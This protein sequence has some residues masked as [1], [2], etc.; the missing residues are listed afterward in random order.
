MKLANAIVT[1]EYNTIKSVT[2]IPRNSVDFKLMS[3][4]NKSFDSFQTLYNYVLDLIKE[5]GYLI[6]YTKMFEA[7]W[8]DI[9]W[10]DVRSPEFVDRYS[11]K[12][13]G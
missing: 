7:R 11:L 10:I 1:H 8:Y 6:P 3:A 4:K 5:S 9:F 13:R 2:V 12:H